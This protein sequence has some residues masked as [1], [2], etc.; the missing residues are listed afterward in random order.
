VPDKD[1]SWKI[2]FE[3]PAQE[4][5]D[6]FAI[7]Y[8][9]ESIYQAMNHFS[10]LSSKY[11]CPG[12]PALISTLLANIN[13]YY[14]HTTA[15]NAV[16]ASDRFAASNFGKEK[17]VKLLNQL[18]N[19]LR[20]DL[21]MYRNNFPSS[22]PD[23]LQDL[24]STVDLL[25]S[26]TFFRMKV[27]ELAS[28]PR[29]STTVKKCVIS[30]LEATYRFL[31]DNCN[32]LFHRNFSNDT[33]INDGLK[34]TALYEPPKEYDLIGPSSTKSLDFWTHLINLI[35]SVIEEDRTVYTP[36]LSQFPSELNV[37]NLSALTMWAEFSKDLQIVLIEHE[38][39][40]VHQRVVKTSQY[41]N[42]HFRV[43]LFYN[44]YVSSLQNDITTD[45]SACFEPF[46]MN[47]LN[48]NDEISMEYL[49]NAFDK[50]KQSEFQQTSEHCVFSS[51]VVDVFTQLNQCYD[52]I[53]KLE[54]PNEDI[55]NRYLQRFALS[56][57]RV[58]LSYANVIRREF[59]TYAKQERI[60]CIL[61]NNIQQARVQ[62]EKTF[63]S[64]GGQ[65]LN[66]DAAAMLTDLQ[67]QLS[68]VIDELSA[69]YAKCLEPTIQRCCEEVSKLLQNVKGSS[70][71]SSTSQKLI[72]GEADLI[73]NPLVDVLHNILSQFAKLCDKTVLKRLLKELWKLVMNNLEKI[74]VLPPIS[75]PRSILALATNTRIEDAYKFLLSGD[76]TKSG[77][78]N[79][80]PKQCQVMECSLEQIK[81]FFHANGDGLKKVF[82]EKSVELQS[83]EYALSLY[84]QTTDAL[85]KTFVR[86]QNQQDL[87]A[88]EEKFGEVSL[89]IDVFTHPVTGEHKITV[90][91]VAANGLKWRTKSMFQPFVEC[92]ICGPHL[93]DK[94][95]QFKTKSKTNSWTPKYNETFHFNIG[96]EEQANMYELHICVKDYC[97]AREDHL[98]GVNVIKL[99]NVIEH[100]S[101]SCWLPLGFR[102]HMDETGWTIL[103][104]LSHRTNDELAKEFVQLKSSQRNKED[105]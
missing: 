53:K 1:D 70:Q 44:Q 5:V 90:K 24:K 47:W 6:E 87:P 16:S 23:R 15:T 40:P 59:S 32:E 64:M 104:I 72:Q 56:I 31:F 63:E 26:I 99:G 89:Q 43:K 98:V 22:S 29:A 60:A 54:C 2:Y 61:M 50:D 28:P 42:L 35:F 58:L 27:Q 83:L 77:D 71:L 65:D 34:T 55:Q 14:A 101:Y 92:T 36:I 25:T 69:M 88:Y 96:N 51:S 100:G 62:L 3:D 78:R 4:V 93:S 19:S 79:L 11:T 105:V 81:S 41:M 74:V 94:K 38:K 39:I 67:S 45:Y 57:S 97:F 84:T 103:R 91:I 17:F 66:K 20:I 102:T 68:K 52:V 8:G 75:D 49:H 86:T 80:T 21:S 13:A 48:D 7:R 76:S 95:R 18:E 10:C 9:I 46:V 82:I 30:C 37:G 73:I 33:Q 85:I 12:V